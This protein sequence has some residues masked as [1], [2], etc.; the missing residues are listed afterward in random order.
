MNTD[1]LAYEIFVVEP[2]AYFE[3]IGEPRSEA[4]HFVFHAIDLK[5]VERRVDGYFDPTDLIR[6]L[7]F[8]E[9][10][11]YKKESAYANIFAK[12]FLKLEQD[13]A[14]DFRATIFFASEKLLPTFDKPYVCLLSDSRV[15]RIFLDTLPENSTSG[16]GLR[17]LKLAAKP[18]IE[19]AQDGNS[20]VRRVKEEVKPKEK[21]AKLLELVEFVVISRLT[22]M[23]REEI[24]NMLE[25][26]DYRKSR[27]YREARQDGVEEGKVELLQEQ[28]RRLASR[29][30]DAG[31]IS[32]LLVVD[33]KFIKETLDAHSS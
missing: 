12:V 19:V 3:A 11:F 13:P 16:F 5:A 29:G 24:R 32:D 26:D 25:L 14:R 7:H 17:I 6:P 10:L 4:D 2:E 31:Q 23:S 33:T 18:K 8:V 15:K 28:I 22:E 1:Q 21:Q 27:F 20:L 9:V 30:Y